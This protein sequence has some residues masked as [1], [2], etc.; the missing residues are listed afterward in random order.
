MNKVM[1]SRPVDI[2]KVSLDFVNGIPSK[3][4]IASYSNV[5][6]YIITTPFDLTTLKSITF[7]FSNTVDDVIE[8]TSNFSTF[9]FNGEQTRIL[10]L[11]HKFHIQ[12][13][14]DN[15]SPKRVI[16]NNSELPGY[17]I[18]NL[19]V[20]NQ[21]DYMRSDLFKI[22]SSVDENFDLTLFAS[23]GKSKIVEHKL[24]TQ[25]NAYFDILQKDDDKLVDLYFVCASKLK[26]YNSLDEVGTYNKER[27]VIR[28][29]KYSDITSLTVDDSNIF[30]PQIFLS[31]NGKTI[32]TD[33]CISSGKVC[34][35]SGV[36]VL[37]E[38]ALDKNKLIITLTDSRYYVEKVFGRTNNRVDRL[39]LIMSYKNSFV[40][41]IVGVVDNVNISFSTFDENLDCGSDVVVS[42]GGK[43]INF[44]IGDSTNLS[45]NV[46]IN[47]V[48]NNIPD[49]SNEYGDVFYTSIKDVPSD[50]VAS[51][52]FMPDLINK[53]VVYSKDIDLS[54]EEDFIY[55]EDSIMRSVFTLF[56][57]SSKDRPIKS[58]LD[59]KISSSLFTVS[60]SLLEYTV[61]S[62]IDNTLRQFE[63]RVN[64]VKVDIGKIDNHTATI[65][66]WF[67]IVKSKVS[68]PLT[69]TINVD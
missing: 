5:S 47:D 26:M 28:E 50:R 56:F 17:W 57:A 3:R 27:F 14:F 69:Y 38:Y 37:S 1:F 46:S 55:N 30:V 42:I 20:S 25:T 16:M 35:I 10:S 22:E 19:Y 34:N 24:P 53:K 49:F 11:N 45:M 2:N 68:V 52:S 41:D 44:F 21:V 6:E 31:L 29:I 8:I 51:S 58:F 13:M 62:Y 23:D 36:N 39:N 64:I 66:M 43:R 4:F 12:M 33:Y 65:T 32:M 67:E 61:M 54:F 15:I 7:E 9:Y 63:P 59:S 40:Y 48:A 60:N 18:N